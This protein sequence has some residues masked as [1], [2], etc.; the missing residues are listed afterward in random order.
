[1]ERFESFCSE[2][3]IQLDDPKFGLLIAHVR[4]EMERLRGNIP[5][6]LEKIKETGFKD[7]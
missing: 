3:S 5:N 4:W 1:M 2:A 6:N 7:N